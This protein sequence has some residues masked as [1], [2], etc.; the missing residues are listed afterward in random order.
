MARSVHCNVSYKLKKRKRVIVAQ[1]IVV[2]ETMMSADEE[3]RTGDGMKTKGG[4]EKKRI[5]DDTKKKE[6][7]MK[8]RDVAG[9]KL[10]QE[11][12]KRKDGDV[13]KKIV[14]EL[15]DERKSVVLQRGK[16]V[17]LKEK[18]LG[19]NATPEIHQMTSGDQTKNVIVPSDT[20]PILKGKSQA[21]ATRKKK[22]RAETTTETV[23]RRV[24]NQ[25]R[26]RGV[27]TTKTTPTGQRA[28][29]A[30]ILKSS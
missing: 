15:K 10:K 6:E 22:T 21:V 29:T 5:V 14:D 12:T 9:T 27:T 30:L 18:N 2:Q 26:T 25:R 11:D 4:D 16:L 3:T 1:E 8:R 7:L 24:K 20:I 19:Q 13:M 17:T 28:R 23:V